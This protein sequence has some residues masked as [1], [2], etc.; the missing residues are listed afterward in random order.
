M[1]ALKSGTTFQGIFLRK[2]IFKN[3]NSKAI[4]FSIITSRMTQNEKFSFYCEP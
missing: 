2:K 1:R 4:I 3:Q